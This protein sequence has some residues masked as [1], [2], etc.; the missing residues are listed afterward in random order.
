MQEEIWKV[1]PQNTNYQISNFGNVKSCI[2]NKK[3]GTWELVYPTDNGYGYLILCTNVN[4][5][6]KNHYVHRL[7][8]QMFVDNPN[9]KPRVNHKD[10]NKKN[11]VYSN[12][13]W[14]TA[15]ENSMHAV[16][17]GLINPLYNRSNH[18]PIIDLETGIFY[19]SIQDAAFSKS[20]SWQT[21]YT[22]L[23]KPHRNKSSLKYA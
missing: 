18:K 21:L 10:G 15:K 17:T 6:R 1:I 4:G 13:E 16:E 9:K 5:K 22:W 23:T 2:R 12:L 20:M 3:S 19:G 8:A 14:S 7:V 11:N